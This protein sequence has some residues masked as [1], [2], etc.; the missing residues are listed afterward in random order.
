MY[1]LYWEGVEG[2]GQELFLVQL[3]GVIFSPVP[4]SIFRIIFRSLLFL[5]QYL[6]IFRLLLGVYLY[7]LHLLLD[8]FL[9]Q[10][11]LLDAL[12]IVS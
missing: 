6:V 8:L 9:V 1:A 12:Y 2:E 11:V 10:H 7:I 4:E 5:V 3:M